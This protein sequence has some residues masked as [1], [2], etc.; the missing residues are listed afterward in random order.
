MDVRRLKRNEKDFYFIFLKRQSCVSL[1]KDSFT[2]L[3][4]FFKQTSSW[5]QYAAGTRPVKSR[6]QGKANHDR[7]F[8]NLHRCFKW[9]CNLHYLTL[10]FFCKRWHLMTHYYLDR[11]LISNFFQKLVQKNINFDFEAYVAS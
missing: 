7:S 2:V 11:I 8:T 6:F 9:F 3:V 10:I 4:D 1:R 5:P